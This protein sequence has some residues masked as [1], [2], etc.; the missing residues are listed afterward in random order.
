MTDID[1]L[2]EE[3][4]NDLHTRM[5]VQAIGNLLKNDEGVVVEVPTINS[6]D[7]T[8]KAI[9]RREHGSIVAQLGEA[10]ELDKYECGQMLWIHDTQ[11]SADAAN[12]QQKAKELH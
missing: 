11:E 10:G 6:E 3:Q 9:V 5:L 8:T 1:D 2:S 7:E 12:V 4:F